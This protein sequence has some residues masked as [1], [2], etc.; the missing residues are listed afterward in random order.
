MITPEY[1]I[2][3]FGEASLLIQIKEEPSDTLLNWLLD[4]CD[5]I[6]STFDIEVVHTYNEVLVKNIPNDRLLEIKNRLPEILISHLI[7]KQSKGILHRI[8]V[9]YDTVFAK[10]IEA[11]S[12]TLGLSISE[13]VQLHTKV[14]YTV[15]FMG[16]LPGF[17]YLEGLNSRLHL[18][19]K[20]TPDRKIM[21]GSIAIGGSQTGIYPQESPG[22]WHCIGQTPI[23]LYN[24]SQKIPTLLNAGDQVLFYEITAGEFDNF[25]NQQ[26]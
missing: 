18:P 13:V 19:R 17:P 1:E 11:Y 6:R 16:F 22:G 12:N 25:K 24:N 14:T 5:Y 20:V 10:D 9:C 21:K 8:P 23:S 4:R 26:E 15:Y 7:H 3:V 2:S